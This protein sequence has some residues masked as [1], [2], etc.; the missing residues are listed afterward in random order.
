MKYNCP[1]CEET[2]FDSM[3]LILHIEE[4]HYDAAGDCPICLMS[5]TDVVHYDVLIPHL[6]EAHD[7]DYET[8]QENMGMSDAELLAEILERSRL[9]FGG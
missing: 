7:F 6:K 2:A 3:N 4:N 8:Y 9:E 1:L 5:G